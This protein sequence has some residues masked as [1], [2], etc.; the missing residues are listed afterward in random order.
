MKNEVHPQLRAMHNNEERRYRDKIGEQQHDRLN[1]I[2]ER[3]GNDVARAAA[4][5]LD[6][7]IENGDPLPIWEIM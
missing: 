4:R 5:E 2:E 7:A 6:K 1:S 3:Y